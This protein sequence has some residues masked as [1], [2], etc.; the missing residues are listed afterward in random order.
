[1]LIIVQR[2]ATIYSL[3]IAAYCFTCF[4]SL[5]PPTIAGGSSSDPTT[6]TRCCKYSCMCCWWWVVSAPE[7]CRAVC[8]N[9]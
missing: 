8:S 4:S 1:M 3:F 9:K 5:Y 6:S 7:T 2:D